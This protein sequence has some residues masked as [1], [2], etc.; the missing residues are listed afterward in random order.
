LVPVA[1]GLA[2]S[3]DTELASMPNGGNDDWGL[4]ALEL[5]SRSR[6]PGARTSPS[7]GHHYGLLSWIYVLYF[8]IRYDR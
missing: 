1:V 6:F 3:A 7:S 8:A 2:F 4:S 5:L